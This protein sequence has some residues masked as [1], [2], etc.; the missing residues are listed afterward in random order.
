MVSVIIPMYNAEKFIEPCLISVLGQ[1]FTNFEIIVVDDCSTDNSYKIVESY[2]PKSGGRLKLIQMKNNSGNP[3]APYNRGLAFARGKYVYFV[4]NDDLILNY[5]LEYFYKFAEQ[6]NLDVV[7]T[8]KRYEFQSEDK[9][10]FPLPSQ[11]TVGANHGGKIYE[12]PTMESDNVLE[13]LIKLCGNGFS[14]P[15]WT[16]FVRRDFLIENDIIFHSLPWGVDTIWTFEVMFLAKRVARTPQPLYIWR[17]HPNST[18]RMNRTAQENIA[19]HTK[20]ASLGTAYLLEFMDKQNFFRENPQYYFMVLEN[21]W[22]SHSSFALKNFATLPPHECYKVIENAL[23]KNFTDKNIV[24]FL[25]TLANFL[26]LRLNVADQKI[27]E[28]ENKLKQI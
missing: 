9:I 2:I 15:A 25:S 5:T 10:Q 28:L 26:R 1:T 20:T 23:S 27:Q 11:V 17:L 22:V 19:F 4:D 16:S 24:S 6:F 12:F 14:R 18:S 7:H 8:D 21:F 13:R 3:A